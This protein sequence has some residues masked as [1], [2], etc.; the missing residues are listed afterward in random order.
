MI[1]L[2]LHLSFSLLSASSLKYI[3]LCYHRFFFLISQSYFVCLFSIFVSLRRNNGYGY[4]SDRFV[5]FLIICLSSR[6][7]SFSW[8]Q[9]FQSFHYSFRLYVSFS[10]HFQKFCLFFCF[11]KIFLILRFRSFWGLSLFSDDHY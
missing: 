3:S 10:L 5:L 4:G 8:L 6:F 9:I 1:V 11:P 2:V 7:F